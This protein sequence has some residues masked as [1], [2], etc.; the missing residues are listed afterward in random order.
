MPVSVIAIHLPK[1]TNYINS[2]PTNK[3]NMI[4]TLFPPIV[5][6]I[7]LQ[8]FLKY[9]QAAVYPKT[10]TMEVIQT[11][12]HVAISSDVSTMDIKTNI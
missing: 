7:C 9:L 8:P 11:L 10:R 2:W 5:P 6:T 3:A 12:Q 1:L 4:I